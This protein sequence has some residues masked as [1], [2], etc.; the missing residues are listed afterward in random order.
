MGLNKGPRPPT[1]H[2]WYKIEY[3]IGLSSN[4]YEF[5]AGV[6]ISMDPRVRS[7]PWSSLH[8]PDVSAKLLL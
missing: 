5:V 1:Q 2:A 6:I 8:G 4:Y 3:K 7:E